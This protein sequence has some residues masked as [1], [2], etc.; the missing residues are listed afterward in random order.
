ML[1]TCSQARPTPWFG[2]LPSVGPAVILRIKLG[3]TLH[4]TTTCDVDRVPGA[5]PGSVENCERGTEGCGQVGPLLERSCQRVDGRVLERS[6]ALLGLRLYL[7]SSTSVVVADRRSQ[8]RRTPAPF[9]GASGRRT[10]PPMRTVAVVIDGH[11]QYPS[12]PGESSSGRRII[13]LTIV[14]ALSPGASSLSGS[15]PPQV[16][17]RP[18]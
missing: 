10:P 16:D 18:A 15:R 17:E 4:Q 2:V 13:W 1:I 9:P 7:R 12:S 6:E 11:D 14:I 3:K 8:G 5:K